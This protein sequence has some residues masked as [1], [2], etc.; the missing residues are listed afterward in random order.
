MIPPDNKNAM[1]IRKIITQRHVDMASRQ[2]IRGMQIMK[3]LD[4]CERQNG[5]RISEGYCSEQI[6]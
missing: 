6:K 4:G 3:H 2:N 1:R 5:K